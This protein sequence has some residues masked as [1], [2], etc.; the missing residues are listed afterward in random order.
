MRLKDIEWDPDSAIG[1]PFAVLRYWGTEPMKVMADMLVEELN[2]RL[3]DSKDPEKSKLAIFA[4]NGL[5][6]YIEDLEETLQ[7]FD[8]E[9]FEKAA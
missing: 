3:Y 6:N 4:A 7:R 5:L 9:L 1:E 8:D 2:L